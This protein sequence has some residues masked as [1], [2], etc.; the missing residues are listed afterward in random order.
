MKRLV[1]FCGFF[2][3]S[4]ICMSFAKNN[5]WH[6][7]IV[8]NN[9]NQGNF[10]NAAAELPF[11]KDWTFDYGIW[12][13]DMSQADK[14]F[15]YLE[16]NNFSLPQEDSLYLYISYQLESYIRY[17]MLHDGRYLDAIN[18]T[19]VAMSIKKRVRGE[20]HPEYLDMGVLL[21]HLYAMVN[22]FDNAEKYANLIWDIYQNSKLKKDSRYASLLELL[23]DLC[24]HIGDYEKAS[25]FFEEKLALCKSKD[26]EKS[27]EYAGY[28]ACKQFR[29]FPR[30]TADI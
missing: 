12:V 9:I 23:G 14:F 26:H 2:V 10:Q 16:D 28:A 4:S 18:Y 3:F 25:A 6:L 7:P 30:R 13:E 22:D 8:V 21:A 5:D 24:V 1:L 29:S 19:K 17:Y 27:L 20:K 15:E 11:V